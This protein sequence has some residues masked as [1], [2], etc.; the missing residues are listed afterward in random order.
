M[1]TTTWLRLALLSALAGCAPVIADVQTPTDATDATDDT[2]PGPLPCEADTVPLLTGQST[3]EGPQ[4]YRICAEL[5]DSGECPP[6]DGAWSLLYDA[7]GPPPEPEF[8]GW[9]VDEV[10]GPFEAESDC[11]YVAHTEILCEGRPLTVHGA[12][13]TASLR[14]GSDWI[15]A[16]P[17]LELGPALRQAAAQVWRRVALAEHASVASF[18]RF[19]LELCAL[20]APPDLL[21]DAAAAQ[22]DEVRHARFA[23]AVLAAL[24]GQ[25]QAP[26]PLDLDGVAPRTTPLQVLRATLLEGCVNETLAAAE[27]AEAARRCPDPELSARLHAV[28]QDESRHA[29]LAWRTV[30]WLLQVHPQLRDPAR[31][32]IRD[33]L[34]RAATPATAAHTDPPAA[35][36]DWARAGLLPPSERAPLAHRVLHQVVRPLADQVI[37]GEPP[38]DPA[39]TRAGQA[40]LAPE[41]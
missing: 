29:A 38:S 9:I 34:A 22:A 11:C 32:V 21:L 8:C 6:A 30:R 1:T 19:S 15:G 26:G 41:V 12:A 35:E 40:G 17:Q 25:A 4:R 16:L 10:C 31:Q 18:A 7:L 14:A 28:A 20:G 3:F 39:R 24:T 23:L 37:E 13:R 5:P 27:V 36:L 2:D 33:A